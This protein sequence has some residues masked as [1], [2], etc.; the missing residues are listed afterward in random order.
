MVGFPKSGHIYER[1]CNVNYPCVELTEATDFVLTHSQP[2][3][4]DQD[5]CSAND[6]FRD[7]LQ[8]CTDSEQ[9]AFNFT[10]K[11]ELK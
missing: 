7:S 5:I 8:N 2:V 11:E 3:F 4:S 6:T 1:G 9:N 10:N